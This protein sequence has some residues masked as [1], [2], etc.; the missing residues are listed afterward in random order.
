MVSGIEAAAIGMMAQQSNLDVLSNNLA[1]VNTAG[2][3]ELIP[4]FQNLSD[5][6]LKEKN[7]TNDSMGNSDK[8]LGILS[9]G[10]ILG[11][12]A[13]NMQQGALRKTDNKLDFALDGEG[14]FAVQTSDGELYTR[15]G[16]FSLNSDGV[17]VTKDGNPVLNQGGS[18]IKL[19]FTNNSFDKFGVRDDGTLLINNQ[20]VDKLK[21]VS[22]DK[23]SD[24]E[25]IGNS[26]YKPNNGASPKEATGCKVEQGFLEGSNSNA[27]GCMINTITATRTY[28]TLSRV[29][30]QSED[31]LAKCVNDVGRVRE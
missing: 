14:F 7:K 9:A 13:I 16:N 17:L 10:S 24:L 3:K 1:N 27:I 6:E 21:V 12:T 25:A 19:D 11:A 31:T 22:F 5:I 15:N 20:E 28:E 8:P 23:T 26:L 29:L 4:V 30:K 2:F 18:E